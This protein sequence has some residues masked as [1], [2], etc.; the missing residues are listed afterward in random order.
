MKES[1]PATEPFGQ[2]I[3]KLISNLCFSVFVFSVLIITVIA[4]TYQP[5]DP[6]LE[7]A[8]ALTK[9]FTDSENA[10][11][12]DDNSVLTTGEDLP[13]AP[14]V[15]PVS[16]GFA[17]ITESVIAKA[18]AKVSNSTNSTLSDG[19]NCE[20]LER[21]N[22]SDPRALI[23][24][25]R[26]NLRWFKNIVF[27]EYQT[28][29]NG[30]KADECDVLWKFRNKKEKSWRKY[31]DFRR[32]KL[33]FGVNCTYKV[34]H[35]GRWHSGI[36][37]RRAS[38]ISSN[39]TRGG[40]KA[41]ITP[42]VRDEQINDTIPS[43]GSDKNFRR[44]RYLY[45]SRGGDYC[46]GMNQFQWSFLCGLG[47]AMYLNR[48]FV[49]DLSVCLAGSYT[50]SNK[51]EEGKD[52]RYYFDYEH[53]KETASIVDE[54]EFLRDWKKWDRIHKKKVPIKK[55]AS[56]KVT[57]MQL[58]KERSTIIWR[59][60]D[61]PEPEN[62]WYRVCEGQAAKY[63]QRPWHALWKSKRLMN[64]VTEIS[65]R[66]D[67]D[68]DAVHVV[69]GEKAQNKQLWPHLD[70]DTSPDMLLN[71][72]KT[73]VQPWRNLYIATNERFYNYFDKLRSQ[74]KVH[75]LDDYK[76][77][78]SNTSEW[79]NETSNLNNGRPVEFDG[80]MRVEVDTEVLYRAKTRVET[81]YNLTADC[82]DGINTC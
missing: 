17:V 31:R 20:D 80:Y 58:K 23:A 40:G 46:K 48:T 63:V 32:F 7:S 28:P 34:V 67:W 36:N 72:V 53:L 71:K 74:Y 16:S 38:R 43:L 30:S 26:F 81:F 73:M 8:P 19:L 47:E 78:W 33:G 11:F 70:Y 29:V 37:G 52:F 13:L 66:M 56:H 75:L 45:Y 14:A 5:P 18:E 10:T 44:G 3:I 24:V 39:G 69:R 41:R 68:F 65:G 9:L 1:N 35:A 64:I 4:I 51:D 54:D 2:N 49:M 21:V 76:E 42:P 55:V 57:P 15:S 12:K 61:G 6:W 60:F 79:Y 25:E 50:L 62:Y 59:Q 77:L 27:L 82:K 22:C